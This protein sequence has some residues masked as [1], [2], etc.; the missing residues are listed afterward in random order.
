MVNVPH[1]PPI[2]KIY[3]IYQEK[4]YQKLFKDF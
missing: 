1:T 2:F 3:I 4:Y